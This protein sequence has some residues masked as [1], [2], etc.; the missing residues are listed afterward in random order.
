MGVS[1]KRVFIVA[2]FAAVMMA[3]M[4]PAQ[5]ST[6][7]TEFFDC[8]WGDTA[9]GVFQE[10]NATAQ[11]EMWGTWKIKH[12]YGDT[13]ATSEKQKYAATKGKHRITATSTANQR[14]IEI[15]VESTGSVEAASGEQCTDVGSAC[16]ACGQVHNGTETPVDPIAIPVGAMPDVPLGDLICTGC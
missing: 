1:R 13:T 12:W 14:V 5:A 8:G 15:H 2:A 16:T 4:L 7:A 10:N 6:S 3:G 9:S 11:W